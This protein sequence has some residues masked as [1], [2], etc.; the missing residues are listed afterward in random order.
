MVTANR[1]EPERIKESKRRIGR[2]LA[3]ACTGHITTLSNHGLVKDTFYTVGKVN[4]L[5]VFRF[6]KA[7]RDPQSFIDPIPN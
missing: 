2:L 7:F 5:L 4:D 6:M 1:Y 3:E